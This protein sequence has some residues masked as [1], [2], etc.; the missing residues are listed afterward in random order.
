MVPVVQW[1]VRS[2][3]QYPAFAEMLKAVFV[4]V[5]RG[6]FER[7]HTV[8]TQSALS[9]LSG[10]HRRDV[11]TLLQADRAAPIASPRPS[12]AS[13]V[14]ARWLSD[15]RYRKRDGKPRELPRTGP[16]RSFEALCRELS[17]DM[18]PR[19][20]LDELMRLGHVG[21]NGERV[22]V[23][24]DAFIPSAR[25]DE[26]TTLF[27]SAA[28]D[29]MA[30]AVGNITLDGPKFLEQSIYA[31]GLTAESIE[32]LHRVARESWKSAFESVFNEARARRD[33][34]ADTDGESRMR[35]GA[36][37]FSEPPLAPSPSSDALGPARAIPIKTKRTRS[38][39]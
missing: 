13:Q 18:H 19:T 7:S 36:Y 14:F 16:G 33:H 26:M 24:V 35:F 39:S 32:R 25:L 3:V 10:V 8:P 34:D 30:A 23:M 11:R 1:L 9:L 28:A 21:L 37:F 20:V 22:V 6:E 12:L 4:E 31:D 2:G 29:H 15:R 27:A 17:N 38:K 5:S